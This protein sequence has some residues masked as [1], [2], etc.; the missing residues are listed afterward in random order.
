MLRR[1]GK[2]NQ[3]AIP[4]NVVKTLRLSP[5][6][7]LDVYIEDNRIILEPKLVIPRDQAYFYTEEWQKEERQAEKDIQEGKV[8]KTDSLKKLFREMD[9]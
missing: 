2:S 3:V 5:D 4:K 8:T 9:S 7:Y 1:L 6:D